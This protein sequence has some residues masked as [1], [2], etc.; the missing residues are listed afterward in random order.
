MVVN[1]DLTI[2]EEDVLEDTEDQ[3][4]AEIQEMIEVVE[5]DPTIKAVKIA[6]VV[7]VDGSNCKT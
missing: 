6:T 2:P 7:V 1:Q 5:K 4:E 3:T